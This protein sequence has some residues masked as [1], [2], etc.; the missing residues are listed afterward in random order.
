M[1]CDT[2]QLDRDCASTLAHSTTESRMT[3]RQAVSGVRTM[4]AHSENEPVTRRRAGAGFLQ[5][6]RSEDLRM[7]NEILA[8]RT[9]ASIATQ[10]SGA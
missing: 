7:A 2:L 10:F 8:M 1:N 5:N 6:I 3:W 9:I 4:K